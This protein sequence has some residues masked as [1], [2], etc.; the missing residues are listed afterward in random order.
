MGKTSLY[1]PVSLTALRGAAQYG[2]WKISRLH[3]LRSD[4]ETGT[5]EYRATIEEGPKDYRDWPARAI[6]RQL[7]HCFMEDCEVTQVVVSDPGL[8][9]VYLKVQLLGAAEEGVA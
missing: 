1:H 9:T 4:V 7:G 6:R 3:Q 2:G 5:A 8:V